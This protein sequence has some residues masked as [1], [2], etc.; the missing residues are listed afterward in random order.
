MGNKEGHRKVRVLF[1]E[2]NPGDARLFQEMVRD[3]CDFRCEFVHVLSLKEGIEMIRQDEF[4]VMLL[5]MGLPESQGIETVRTAIDN[6]EDIPIIVLTG[7]DD[8]ETAIKS[9]NEGVQDYMVKDQVDGNI[10]VRSILYSIE[11]KRLEVALR[12]AIMAAAAASDAKTVFLSNMSHEIRTP[13]NAIMG[14]SELALE[15]D[16]TDDQRELLEVIHSNSESLLSILNDI[17]DMAKIEE[18]KVEL[19]ESLF[20]PGDLVRDVLEIFSIQAREKGVELASA[21]SSEVSSKYFGD[22]GRLRQVL[23]NLVGN[24]IKFTSE[25]RIEVRVDKERGLKDDVMLHFQISDTGVGIS[26]PDRKKIFEKFMQVDGS[27]TRKEGG[28]GLGLSISKGLVKMMGGSIWVES[29][30]GKGSNFHFNIAVR[31]LEKVKPD[32]AGHPSPETAGAAGKVQEVKILLVD[33]NIDSRNL[34]ER[35]LDKAGYLLDTVEDGKKAVD[36]VL[37]KKYDVILMDIRMPVMGGFEAT[38]RI[39]ALEAEKGDGRRTPIIA[40]TAHA[41]K[42]ERERAIQLGM[43]DYITKPFRKKTLLDT[44]SQWTD[45]LQRACD[46]VVV[47]VDADVGDLVPVFLGN[48][49]SDAADITS[50]LGKGKFEEIGR[51]GHSMKGT[52]GGYGFDAISEIG[53]DLENA[54]RMRDNKKIAELN[55]RLVAYLQNVKVEIKDE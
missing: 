9:I 39:R 7:L 40:L 38:E 34:V 28:T 5:D 44:I 17:L 45:S 46:E 8:E 2:D 51:I 27:T 54:A 16:L 4:D 11:R 48:R 53:N 52:G 20:D 55:K 23:M 3:R 32:V 29:E 14:M 6:M 25:G 10:I 24:A 22:Q 13:M 30:P 42:E 49:R 43:D 41:I 12:E 33:D 47:H 31:H 26:E 36:A 15:T 21:L 50:L 1:I 35:I 19:D 37:K 18:G